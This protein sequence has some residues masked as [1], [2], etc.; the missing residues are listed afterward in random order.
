MFFDKLFRRKKSEEMKIEE[1]IEEKM[2]KDGIRREDAIILLLHQNK[3]PF[4]WIKKES[5]TELV[6]LLEDEES[7]DAV[8]ELAVK[9]GNLSYWVEVFQK[10]ILQKGFFNHY[11]SKV[12]AVASEEIRKKIKESDGD[13]YFKFAVMVSISEKDDDELTNFYYEKIMSE[14]F[15]LYKWG[16]CYQSTK[17]FYRNTSFKIDFDFKF[18]KKI[19]KNADSFS[20]QDWVWIRNN[21]YDLRSY[22]L[23]EMKKMQG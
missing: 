20:Y 6:T 4:S 9:N 19:R 11:E 21:V 22:A 23:G 18:F 2:K 8:L 13:N 1:I 15:D 12:E 7:V 16:S 5:L 10:D 17:E 14:K 3:I